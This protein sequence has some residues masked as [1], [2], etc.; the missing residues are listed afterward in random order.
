[1][2]TAGVVLLAGLVG[3]LAWRTTTFIADDDE[4]RIE[5]RLIWSSSARIDYS[6][7]QSVDVTQPFVARLLGLGKV[8]IDVGGESEETSRGASAAEFSDL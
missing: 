7:V 4:F 1:M 5:R 3:V 6:K 8:Q 2:I